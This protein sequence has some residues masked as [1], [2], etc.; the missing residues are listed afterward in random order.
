MTLSYY[1]KDGNATVLLTKDNDTISSAELENRF[2]WDAILDERNLIVSVASGGAV[3][4]GL[5]NSVPSF[6]SLSLS[7]LYFNGKIER[8][9]KK[10]VNPQVSLKY[11]PSGLYLVVS[12]YLGN[13]FLFSGTQLYYGIP[14]L[15][16]ISTSD[17]L[18]IS[19]ESTQI[20]VY[21][22]ETRLVQSV[23]TF[24]GIAYQS[25]FINGNSMYLKY[26]DFASKGHYVME[27]N[28]PKPEYSYSEYILKRQESMEKP[29]LNS[30]T[31]PLKEIDATESP[32]ISPYEQMIRAYYAYSFLTGKKPFRE[33]CSWCNKEFVT[34]TQDGG[35][36]Y[37]KDLYGECRITESVTGKYHSKECALKGCK[38]ND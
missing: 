25:L 23:N 11:S 33:N 12:N 16:F 32:S 14:Y 20:T 36:V 15:N 21:N 18:A 27:F 2:I 38:A 17:N 22:L 24:K 7:N 1:N 8:F 4:D 29:I 6:D 35:F 9:F 19:L 34:G 30:L 31:T 5:G 37:R 3:G 13:A 28:V 10:K 26:C